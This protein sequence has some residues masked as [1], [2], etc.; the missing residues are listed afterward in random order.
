[1]IQL[2]SDLEK[3]LATAARDQLLQHKEINLEASHTGMAYSLAKRGNQLRVQ[4]AARAW[5]LK[6]ARV[7]SVSPGVISTAM[8]QKEFEGPQGDSMRSMIE[9]SATRRIGTPD[10][11]TNAVAF[12]VGSDSDFITGSDILVDGGAVSSRRWHTA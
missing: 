3:H 6:G 2:S 7:N 12:L 4:G 1:M 8:A 11:I 5:G 10:D 9:L